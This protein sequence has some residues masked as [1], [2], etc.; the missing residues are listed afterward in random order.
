MR[1][2]LRSVL[3]S[4]LA[5]AG[6]NDHRFGFFPGTESDGGT[7]DPSTASTDSPTLSPT[8]L[9]PT[10]VSPT[11]VQP[12]TITTATDT[13]TTITTEPTTLT[14][15]TEP[16]TECGELVLPPV[17]P[18]HEIDSLQAQGDDFSLTCGGIGGTDLE[19][20]WTA[21]VT[22]RFQFDTIGSSF[23]SL[24]A[25]IDG[26]CFG[27][28]LACD[29]DGGGNLTSRVEVDLVVGQTVTLVIDSFGQSSAEVVYNI[30]QVQVPDECPD[31]VFEPFVPL[32]ID[33]QTAGAANF[34]AGSCNGFESP[35]IEALW[36][37]PF[38]G[39]FVF[40]VIE[41]DFDPVLYLLDG[42]CQG[43][44]LACNDDSNGLFPQLVIPMFA[45]QSVVV[46]VDGVGG[47][48]GKFLLSIHEA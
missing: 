14:V 34:R 16:P 18:I 36:T 39:A 15:T 19:V 46:V 30:T 38:D 32:T 23:D 6:C 45:G 29:D 3:A 48:A 35:E 28:E 33:G 41:A 22:G 11:T 25:V 17:V 12:T 43:G 27:Q 13:E 47:Q 4:G 40:E 24:L 37:A 10:T 26:V 9:V 1:R 2:G 21:P 44:E 31:G 5:L 7:F 8:T 20:V 42:S